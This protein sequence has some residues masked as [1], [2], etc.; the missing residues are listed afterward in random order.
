MRNLM[1]ALFGPEPV[2]VAVVD[3]IEPPFAVIESPTGQMVDVPLSE[4]PPD[5]DEGDLVLYRL[6]RA[7]P[8]ARA[9]RRT[10]ST[11]ALGPISTR[12]NP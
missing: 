6:E 3:R 4:L 2:T 5:V 12:S 7:A 10:P 11:R 1:W 9:R 8:R